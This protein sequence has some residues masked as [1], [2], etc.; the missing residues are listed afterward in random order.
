MH[1]AGRITL[2]GR[3]RR[4]V[5]VGQAFKV[6]GAGAALGWLQV[7]WWV[8]QGTSFHAMPSLVYKYRGP[9]CRVPLQHWPGRNS[10]RVRTGAVRHSGDTSVRH[11]AQRQLETRLRRSRFRTSGPDTK[12][13]S[14]PKRS[15]P[16]PY[17]NAPARCHTRGPPPGSASF[18]LSTC[19]SPRALGVAE[20]GPMSQGHAAS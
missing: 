12:I 17:S 16:R 7:P 8:A 19:D 14:S 15:T 6:V 13:I 5:A 2:L 9:A 10:Y 3:S 11:A 18:L 1:Q 20:E 4:R